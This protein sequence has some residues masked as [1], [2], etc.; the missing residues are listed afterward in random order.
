MLSF[1]R[2]L[3]TCLV[4][5]AAWAGI[6]QADSLPRR[7]AVPVQP[8]LVP[9]AP[10]VI[11]VQDVHVLPPPAL[12]A[13]PAPI[14]PLTHAEFARVFQPIPGHHQVVLLHPF[15]KCPVQVCFTLPPGCPKKVRVDRGELEFDY[16][17][18]EIEIRFA[19]NGTVRVNY[20]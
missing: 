15:T 16:G 10:A 8:V 6:A 20:D 4:L 5:L 17:R 9:A 2:S 18:R 11:Q 13:T 3:G 1:P 14:R 19:R 12:L 7:R